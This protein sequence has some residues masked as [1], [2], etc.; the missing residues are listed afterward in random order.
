MTG[1]V[2]VVS[3]AFLAIVVVGA[4]A[5]GVNVLLNPTRTAQD[6]LRDLR[7][8]APTDDGFAIGLDEPEG[9]VEQIAERLG[10]LAQPASEEDLNRLR[11]TLQHAGYRNRHALEVFNGVRVTAALVLPL[12]VIPI[13]SGMSLTS[14]AGAVVFAAASGY[15]IPYL[16]LRNNVEKRKR[17][18]LSAFPDSLDL[19]V[20]SVEAG[21]GLDAAFRR[22]AAEMD[23]ATPELARE[24]Q[25]VNHEISAGISRVDA[26]RH[27][28]VRTGLDEVRSLVNMLAQ[29]ER[30]GTSVAKSLRVHAKVVRQK[31]MAR[32]E[33]EAA[34]VSPK[35]TV[36]MILFLLPVLMSIL[37]GPAM[38]R[39]M[40]TFGM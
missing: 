18:L 4:A 16:L 14:L 35:L 20:S 30:F 2:L 24:F 8:Q 23:A 29:S 22:V 1:T 32:A 13:A 33:E 40:N 37:M 31:R 39:V 9:G 11:Q 3:I 7:E 38:I 17:V 10:R 34:K 6:R 26:L 21:L 15:Y 12:F 28:E 5:Y 19:L 27:L 36:V 25:L